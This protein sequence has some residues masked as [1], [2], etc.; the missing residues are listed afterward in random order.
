MP[1]TRNNID[2]MFDADTPMNLHTAAGTSRGRGPGADHSEDDSS[3]MVDNM[4]GDVDV[5]DLGDLAGL[6]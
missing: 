1:T 6:A 4:N 3:F 2:V 5:D